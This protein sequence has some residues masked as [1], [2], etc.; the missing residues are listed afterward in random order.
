[1]SVYEI[2]LVA[3]AQSFLVS[4]GGTEYRF[5]VTYLDVDGGGYLLSIAGTDGTP[6]V[7]SIPMV[8][9]AD[10]LAQYQHLSIGGG[11]RMILQT[12]GDDTAVPTYEGL[13]T[14]S[15]LYF[16]AGE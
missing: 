12:D 13:G 1:M 4:L 9:G 16:V 7:S 15:R 10:L 11:G 3:G 5:T 14:T 6:I 8:T 2:P